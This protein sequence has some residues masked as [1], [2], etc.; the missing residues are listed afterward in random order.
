MKL[1]IK[2]LP[3]LLLISFSLTAQEAFQLKESTMTISGTS[4]LHDWVSNVV[5][6]NVTADISLTTT[7]LEDI[8]KME[9]SLSVKDIISS[10]GKKMD[11]KTYDALKEETFPSIKYTLNKVS[12]IEPLPKG[13]YGYKV[14]TSGDLNL[15]GETQSIELEV[16]AKRLAGGDIKFE[17]SKSLLM[18][19]FGITPPKA[20]LGTLKTGD[21]VTIDFTIVLA[22]SNLN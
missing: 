20:L 9:V 10:K 14:K 3:L 7:A 6:L 12:S 17:G 11:K 18:T 2:I 15:A 21:E 16:I 22:P 4:S 13:Q 5:E 8:S 19:S 1:T